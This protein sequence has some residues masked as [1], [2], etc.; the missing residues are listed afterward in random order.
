MM[1]QQTHLEIGRP[2]AAF[3]VILFPIVQ[4][5]GLGGLLIASMMAGLIL[6][7]LGLTG[8]GQALAAVSPEEAAKLDSELTPFG[9]QRAA[10]AR[11]WIKPRQSEARV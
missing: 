11:M 10:F 7:A 9:A 3:V 2:T 8:M 4:Q 5:Y 1:D 6:V